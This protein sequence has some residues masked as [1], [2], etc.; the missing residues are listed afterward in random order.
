MCRGSPGSHT[1]RGRL[2]PARGSYESSRTAACLRAVNERGL[3]AR[4]EEL[5]GIQQAVQLDEFGHEPRP[6]GLMAGAEPG[7]VVAVE[8][9]VEQNV[10][11]PVRI[12][13]ELLGAAVDRPPA[14]F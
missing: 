3:L 14:A 10:V 11:V 12:G 8:V 1:P 13:L 9:L 7:A 2:R 4:L 5:R 6:S